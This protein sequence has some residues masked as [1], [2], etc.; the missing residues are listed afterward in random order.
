M[1]ANP[2]KPVD[3]RRV[4]FGLY[5]A[6]QRPDA[7]FHEPEC[8]LPIDRQGAAVVDRKES[9]FVEI[10]CTSCPSCQIEKDE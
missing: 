3:I 4:G 5:D 1:L 6:R 7:T 9:Q 8:R 2:V 10:R